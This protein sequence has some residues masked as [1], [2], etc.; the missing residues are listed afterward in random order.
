MTSK[1]F[2]EET[3]N[4]HLGSVL[5]LRSK[6]YHDLGDTYKAQLD[7]QASKR[8]YE[9]NVGKGGGDFATLRLAAAIKEIGNIF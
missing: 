3:N 2:P 8:I 4:M 7:I 9:Y 6:I 5:F 1:I